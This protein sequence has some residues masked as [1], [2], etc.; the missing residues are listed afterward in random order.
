MFNFVQAIFTLTNKMTRI[1]IVS[2]NVGLENILLNMVLISIR[3]KDIFRE[4]PL[5]TECQKCHVS[6]TYKCCE[7][8]MEIMIIFLQMTREDFK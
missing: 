6:Y 4:I 3:T 7:K 2:L 1:E 8:A 5:M